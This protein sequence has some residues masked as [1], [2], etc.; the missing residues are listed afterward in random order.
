MLGFAWNEASQLVCLV[1]LLPRDVLHLQTGEVAADLVDQA[2][3]SRQVG[4]VD[5]PRSHGLLDDDVVVTVAMKLRYTELL[6]DASP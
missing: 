5:I 2:S 4:L 6:G 3:V 1:I